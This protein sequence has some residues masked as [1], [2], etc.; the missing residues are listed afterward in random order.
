MTHKLEV[1]K[2]LGNTIRILISDGR[3]IEGEFSC[4]DKELNIILATS[5]EYHGVKAENGKDLLETKITIIQHC[6][7][8]FDFQHYFS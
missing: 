6:F 2:L 7:L 8:Y 5:V 3:V 1:T 4:I